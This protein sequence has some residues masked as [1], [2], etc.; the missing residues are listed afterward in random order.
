VINQ[1][2][3]LLGSLLSL[4]S[5]EWDEVAND[6]ANWAWDERG[7]DVGDTTNKVA[8]CASTWLVVDG[9]LV[10]DWGRSCDGQ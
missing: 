3:D 1:V 9:R 10:V 7:D 6:V 2:S 4:N 8:D 5:P